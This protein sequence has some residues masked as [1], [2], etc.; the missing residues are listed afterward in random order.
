M[1]LAVF[2][3]SSFS[4]HLQAM[5]QSQYS[6]MGACISC[7]KF[8]Q[9]VK[10][11]PCAHPVCQN[12]DE[13]IN[14]D[15]NNLGYGSFCP[16]CEA[17]INQGTVLSDFQGNP[18]PNEILFEPM[19]ARSSFLQKVLLMMLPFAGDDFESMFLST[20][21]TRWAGFMVGLSM[22]PLLRVFCKS[23]DIKL[24]LTKTQNINNLPLQIT[25]IMARRAKA[26]QIKYF[27]YSC[28]ASAVP[29]TA[30]ACWNDGSKWSGLRITAASCIADYL[31][32][33]WGAKYENIPKLK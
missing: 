17:V 1:A 2:C 4:T 6:I 27:F 15:Y 23:Q 10:N 14:D 29:L 3:M 19:L 31:L 28:A 7:N 9:Q 8:A 26:F 21:G 13:Q 5:V 20:K 33:E 18:I 32:E 11:L 22:Q 12:C 16:S 30:F 25:Q 24:A